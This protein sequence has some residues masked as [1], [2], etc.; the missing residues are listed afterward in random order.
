MLQ[1]NPSQRSEDQTSR[2]H[3]LERQDVNEHSTFKV[4]SVYFEMFD[5]LTCFGMD[6]P[7]V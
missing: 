6:K 2:G 7:R 5:S 3:M 4:E 1:R